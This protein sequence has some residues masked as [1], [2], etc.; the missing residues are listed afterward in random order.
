M[1]GQIL[2][3]GLATPLLRLFDYRWPDCGAGDDLPVPGRG[4]RIIVPFG[5]KTRIGV[6]VAMTDTS[7][8]PATKL[9]KAIRIIDAEPLLDEHLMALLEWAADY[10][11]HA[12]GEVIAAALP[13]LLRAGGAV[14]ATEMI[15]RVTEPGRTVAIETLAKRAP[16][17]ARIIELLLTRVD[18]ADATVLSAAG[19]T[20]R[21]AAAKLVSKTLLEVTEQKVRPSARSDHNI[22]AP[23]AATDDQR[24]AIEAITAASGFAA[25]LLEG[26]T[27]SGKTEVYLRCIEL[28]LERGR[29]SLLLV[30]EIGLTPQLVDRFRRRLASNIAVLH[31][32]LN[33]TERLMA[34]RMARNGSAGV[35]IGTRSAIFTPLSN[36]GLI[37]IDEEH[38]ASLKQQDGF[39]YSARDLAVW[40]ARQL[41]IPIV[42]GSATPSFE[43]LE[44]VNANRYTKLRLPKRPG[45]AR[46]PKVKLIDLRNQP[47]KDGLTDPLRIAIARHLADDGQVLLYLNR[48]GFAPS[49]MCTSCGQLVECRRCDARL[50]FHQRRARLICHHC[51]AEHAV[52]HECVACHEPDLL[53]VGQGT[54]RLEQALQ[55]L[56]APHH[57]IRIDRDTTRRKGEIERRLKLVRSGAARI[58]LGTQMLTKGHDFPNVTMVGIID[59]DQGLFGTDFRSSE[60]LAQSFIQVA[61]RA[62]RSDRP[63]EVYIQTLFPEHPLLMTLIKEGYEQFAHQALDE[64]KSA[65]WPPYTCLALTRAEAP[66][67]QTAFTFLNEA[68]DLAAQLINTG[69]FA[70]I[71]W[72][73]P[74]SAPMERRSGRYRGQLLIQADTR[75]QLQH[76]LAA[77]RPALDELK[78]ARKTRWSVDVDPTELF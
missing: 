35:I 46:Q 15:W 29:Q 41:D 47:C 62:G 42:L 49:M 22:E 28:E 61:G 55:E 66:Q 10:Y 71:R 6:I 19:K 14:D 44:N 38:D 2:R 48:R 9:R 1:T 36:P 78:S 34:W 16:V 40:R 4:K 70:G 45:N 56:F 30:P 20:W 3:V 75:G 13:K 73:G 5:K 23:L 69:G 25:F 11:R 39:R 58:L 67:R 74:A 57:I 21:T 54:E 7:P 33:D 65:G 12:P 59:A 26:V 64:R 32:G 51:G 43:S 24:R 17:Q 60:R 8:V 68:R 76:F 77:W 63:G 50:V 72:L 31:S 53:P 18:G 27:G 37:I 52:P